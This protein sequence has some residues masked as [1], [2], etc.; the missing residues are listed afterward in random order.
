[1]P[2]NF[3]SV[4]EIQLAHIELITQYWLSSEK[5]FLTNMGVDINKVP[6]RE[7]WIQ[8][9]TTQINTPIR[10]RK[11]YCIIW[12]VDGKPV[13]HSNT[14]PTFFGKEAYMH[15]HIWDS[16]I[17]KKGVG[18]ALLKLT[19]PLFFE[20]LQLKKLISEPYAL[21]PAP[22]KTLEKA[23]FQMVKEYTTTPGPL[24]F[25]QPVKRWELSYEQFKLL[26]H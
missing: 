11:S 5:S 7:Q 1:M 25:E 10:E 4:T 18:T 8:M 9:L 24:N 13:G 20:K 23:C 19:L 2:E 22:N 16:N 26:P 21:N 12:Q 14:N 6:V 15:L 3:L 17:R